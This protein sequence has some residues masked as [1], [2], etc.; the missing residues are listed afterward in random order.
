MRC[1]LTRRSA[2]QS[3]GRAVV[4]VALAWCYKKKVFVRFR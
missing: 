1:L 3:S 2:R 4:V